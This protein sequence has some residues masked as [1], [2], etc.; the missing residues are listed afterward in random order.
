MSA[1]YLAIGLLFGDGGGNYDKNFHELLENTTIYYEQALDSTYTVKFGLWRQQ[2]RF[3]NPSAFTERSRMSPIAAE[4]GSKKCALL[5]CEY[6]HLLTPVYIVYKNS[7]PIYAFPHANGD[8]QECYPID[9]S[10][11]VHMVGDTEMYV[12]YPNSVLAGIENITVNVGGFAIPTNGDGVPSGQFFAAGAYTVTYRYKQYT[13]HDSYTEN[14][15]VVY[16]GERTVTKT[17]TLYSGNSTYIT[18]CNYDFEN[19][20][21]TDLSN[22]EMYDEFQNVYNSLFTALG[23][24]TYPIEILPLPTT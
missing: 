22:D 24:E 8:Y 20:Y 10:R 6:K 1:R 9:Y 18:G 7:D 15:Y 17:N 2:G 19:T 14:P 4:Y 3:G 11:T 23:I 5:E 21:Y 13:D 12:F 16:V